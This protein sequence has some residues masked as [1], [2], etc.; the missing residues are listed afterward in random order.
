MIGTLLLPFVLAFTS[1]ATAQ[2]PASDGPSI[3]TTGEGTVKL[4]PDRAWVSISAE[5]RARGPKEAQK[6]NADAMTAV[7]GKLI[8]LGFL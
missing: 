2:A 6:A 8:A 4:A 3:V 1:P 5:S 7:L